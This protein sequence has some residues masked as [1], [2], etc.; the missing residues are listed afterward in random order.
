M[1][2]IAQAARQPSVTKVQRNSW[3]S[4]IVSATAGQHQRGEYR[5]QQAGYGA[6]ARHRDAVQA[7]AQA[8]HHHDVE[9]PLEERGIAVADRQDQH[10]GRPDQQLAAA[11]VQRPFAAFG[12]GHAGNQ[13]DRPGQQIAERP[14]DLQTGD[15]EREH[16]HL[17][18]GAIDMSG[19]CD[20]G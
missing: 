8:D 3:A 15:I 2:P 10:V 5:D 18:A 9:K 14:H 6:F 1:I 13:M 7:Q 16:S 17:M 4:P 19:R 12:P 11:P 20:R